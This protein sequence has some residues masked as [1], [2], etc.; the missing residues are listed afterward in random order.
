M[1][2]L[3]TLYISQEDN[4]SAYIFLFLRPQWWWNLFQVELNSCNKS[5]WAAINYVASKLAIFDSRHTWCNSFHYFKKKCQ[6]KLTKNVHENSPK[7]RSRKFTIKD[8]FFWTKCQQEFTKSVNENS[9]I[10][11]MT[12]KFTFSTRSL[13]PKIYNFNL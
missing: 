13:P 10:L 6:L 12:W 3:C 4:S 8:E 11:S 9:P 2:C 1:F 7:T 5:L